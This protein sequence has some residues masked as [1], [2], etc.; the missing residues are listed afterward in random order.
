MFN[1]QLYH[2]GPEHTWFDQKILWTFHSTRGLKSFLGKCGYKLR[3]ETRHRWAIYYGTELV[4]FL[5]IPH[6]RGYCKAH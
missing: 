2:T 6:Y 4:G 3:F 1:I 5:K